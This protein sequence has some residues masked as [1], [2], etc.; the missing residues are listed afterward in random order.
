MGVAGAK[1]I[2]NTVKIKGA[3]F[4][5]PLKKHKTKKPPKTKKQ[6]EKTPP[7][8]KREGKRKWQK[9]KEG[10]NAVKK[11]LPL[12]GSWNRAG[13]LYVSTRSC[14]TKDKSLLKL[15]DSQCQKLPIKK[16][17]SN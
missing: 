14:S 8:T 10:M 9:E 7:K 11:R 2:K 17:I 15:T 12:S 4:F 1:V 3:P 16:V 13:G 5:F 6:T